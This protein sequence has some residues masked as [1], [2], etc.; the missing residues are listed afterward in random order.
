[1]EQNRHQNVLEVLEDY[2]NRKKKKTFGLH[3][4]IDCPC[5][6]ECNRSKEVFVIS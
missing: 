3:N 6:L 4:K 2:V 1:M 5:F